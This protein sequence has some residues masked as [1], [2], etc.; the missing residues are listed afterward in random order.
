MVVAMFISAIPVMAEGSDEIYFDFSENGTHKN[1][2]IL[3]NADFSYETYNARRGIYISADTERIVFDIDSGALKNAKDIEINVEYYDNAPGFFTVGYKNTDGEAFEEPALI[4]NSRRWKTHTFRIYDAVLAN[5]YKGGDFAVE[6]NTSKYGKS[7]QP[8][9]L[10]KVT[11]KALKSKAAEVEVTS[12]RGGNVF[13]NGE[14]IKFDIKYSN[15]VKKPLEFDIKYT[16]KNSETGEV[17]YEAADSLKLGAKTPVMKTI[18]FSADTFGLY[19]LEIEMT[20]KAGAY[21]LYDICKFSYS[22]YNSDVPPNESYGTATHFNTNIWGGYQRETDVVAPIIAASGIGFI[23]DEINWQQY[24]NVK[25]KY[26]INDIDKKY[27]KNID[28]NELD[29]LIILGYKNSLYQENS[30]LPETDEELEAF[31]KYCYN[32]VKEMGD[33]CTMYEVWNEPNGQSAELYFPVLKVAYENVKKANP[34]ATV[35]GCVT[36]GIVP[37]YFTKIFELGGG[38]YMDTLS[39]HYYF[40]DHDIMDDFVNLYGRIMEVDGLIQKYKPSLDIVVSEFGWVPNIYDITEGVRKDIYLKN[41]AIFAKVPRVTKSVWYEFQDSGISMQDTERNYGYVENWD[42]ET[43]YAAHPIYIA[44]AAYNS[45]IG[46]R[47][48]CEQYE[49][50]DVYIYRYEK[51]YRDND[52]MMLW[53]ENGASTV[54]MRLGCDSVTLYDSYGNGRELYGTDGVFNF[55]LGDT[56]IMVEGNFK[57]YEMEQNPEIKAE[58]HIEV[59]EGELV[60]YEPDIPNDCKIQYKAEDNIEIVSEENNSITFKATGD[61]GFETFID[62]E[63]TRDDKLVQYGKISVVIGESVS[64]EILSLPYLV[65]NGKNVLCV[66]IKNRRRDRAI[67]GTFKLKEPNLIAKKLPSLNIQNIQPMSEKKYYMY[68]P[69]FDGGGYFDFAGDFDISGVCTVSVNCKYDVSYAK[70]CASVPNIDGIISDG[71]YDKDCILK[72]VNENV[73]DLF[74]GANRGDK[75]LSGE[76][77]VTWD[78]EKLYIAAEITDDTHYQVDDASMMWRGDSIQF[79]VAD[80]ELSPVK[81]SEIMLA[82]RGN[83]IQMS[84][85][86]NEK[87]PMDVAINRIDDKTV[88]EIAVPFAGIFGEDWKVT[89]KKSIGFSILVNDN[90]GPDVRSTQAGR[91]GWIEY[92]SGIGYT[93]S[94]WLYADLKLRN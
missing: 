7:Y 74:E 14:N 5:G 3:E 2:S 33:S 28:N 40:L 46:D 47:K 91:K 57:S 32:L 42:R 75:D 64:A 4:G 29:K 48:I 92:G 61:V 25:G 20:D 50:D 38:E 49:E 43:P 81:Y 23:R 55:M 94:P 21:G 52:T 79:A 18:E 69:E 8:L 54:S 41:M 71:E 88:Y 73:V 31:G 17:I 22:K 58:A 65:E 56:P 63:I 16:A 67:S 72:T 1:L 45:I 70:K 93:K 66:N 35:M 37:D 44:T 15:L 30:V 83:Q 34:N 10:G 59:T 36:A 11:V 90:D 12:K 9:I 78:D 51:N 86:D 77:Y 82:K 27:L 84:G 39:M 26:G 87:Y 76:Y 60:A 19:L 6:L 53:H 62:V 24:E 89:D 85:Y 13:V 80:R 68:I